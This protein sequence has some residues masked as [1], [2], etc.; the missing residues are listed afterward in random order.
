[1]ALQAIARCHNVVATSNRVTKLRVA[2]PGSIRRKPF[3]VASRKAKT[4]NS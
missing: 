3:N 4:I 2:V 1:M